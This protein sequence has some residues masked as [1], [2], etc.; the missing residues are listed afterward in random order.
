MQSTS[1]GKCYLWYLL[2]SFWGYEKNNPNSV[3]KQTWFVCH[4]K[5]SRKA[6]KFTRSLPQSLTR[7]LAHLLAHSPA[8]PPAHLLTSLKL[9]IPL[10]PTL[11]SLLAP[12]VVL[13]TSS[14]TR[15]DELGIAMIPSFQSYEKP[16]DVFFNSKHYQHVEV[17][18]IYHS[19]MCLS[20]SDFF[21]FFSF[22]RWV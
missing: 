9:G 18:C 3:L 19:I 11:M 8:H 4:G 2:I 10:M 1:K 13:K 5:C 17:L 7:S 20:L 15:D 12:Q 21:F 14:A 22:C 16:W 6:V